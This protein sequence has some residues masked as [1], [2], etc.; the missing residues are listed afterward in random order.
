MAV[1]DDDDDALWQST[2]GARGRAQGRR[3]VRARVSLA[4]EGERY[5]EAT[6]FI[7]VSLFPFVLI[8]FPS[9]L[10]LFPWSKAQGSRDRLVAMYAGAC[11]HAMCIWIAQ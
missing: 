8:L 1:G 4:G 5:G 9:V 7:A 11:K 2:A 3:S 10:I 6:G